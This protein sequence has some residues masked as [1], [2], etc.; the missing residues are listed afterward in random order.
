M[1]VSSAA[2]PLLRRDTEYTL[3]E[4]PLKHK[5]SLINED[6]LSVE[7]SKV[8]RS[9]ISTN[10]TKGGLGSNTLTS[11]DIYIGVGV[12][13]AC[14]TTTVDRGSCS[15]AFYTFAPLGEAELIVDDGAAPVWCL[16]KNSELERVLWCHRLYHSRGVLAGRSCDV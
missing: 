8:L 12:N 7:P 16:G 1:L 6:E 3:R 11:I 5:H 13:P 2:T 9:G 14:V 10:E 4:S 15:V